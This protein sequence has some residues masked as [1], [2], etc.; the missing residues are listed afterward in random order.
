MEGAAGAQGLGL[1]QGFW[2]APGAD[3]LQGT[4]K[5]RNDGDVSTVAPLL[6]CQPSGQAKQGP[7]IHARCVEL[8][9]P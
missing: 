4:Q 8:E 7:Y 5:G 6:Q 1:K 3:A 9:L 2:R